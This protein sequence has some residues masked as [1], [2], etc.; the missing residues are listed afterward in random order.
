MNELDKV[1]G[2]IDFSFMNVR[3]YSACCGADSIGELFKNFGRCADC[4]E[5]VDFKKADNE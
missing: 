5:M 4:L 2:E 3:I 1:F